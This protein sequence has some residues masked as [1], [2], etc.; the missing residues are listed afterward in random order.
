MSYF[1]RFILAIVLSID[2]MAAS[3][4]YGIKFN[5][6][7]LKNALLLS[8]VTGIF[9]GIMPVVSYYLTNIVRT[10]IYPYSGLIV[11]LIFSYLGS[12]IIIETLQPQEKK[13]VTINLKNL[14]LIGIAT[15]IDAFSAGITLSLYG[16]NIV[17][18]AILIALVTFLNSNL[19]FFAGVKLK[20]LSTKY[21]EL[22]AGTILICL[23][24]KAL[25]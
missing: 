20:K 7:F 6:Q 25:L 2:A 3:F 11:F 15:S 12:K 1:S 8:V 23:G 17:K 4:S 19:G 16:N 24:I 9:Q 22:F 14:F 13:E 5:K 10:Y 18:P 21:L